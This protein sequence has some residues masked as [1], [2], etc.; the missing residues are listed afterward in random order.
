MIDF[1]TPDSIPDEA[2]RVLVGPGVSKIVITKLI[3][4]HEIIQISSFGRIAQI[5]ID[6]GCFVDN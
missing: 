6:R 1:L 3:N 4:N 2:K 5:I